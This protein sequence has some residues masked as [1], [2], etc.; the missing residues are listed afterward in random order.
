MNEYCNSRTNTT[1]KIACHSHFAAKALETYLFLMSMH[2]TI[3]KIYE[4]KA[5]VP[6]VFPWQQPTP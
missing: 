6:R 1:D 5:T 4:S 3:A 2:S